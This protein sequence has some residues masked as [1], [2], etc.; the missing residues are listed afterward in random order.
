MTKFRCPVCDCLT[1]RTKHSYEICP[2]CYWEDADDYSY[3]DGWSYCNG[4]NIVEAK[5]SFVSIGVCDAEFIGCVRKPLKDE[6]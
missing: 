1:L 6:I 3:N 2:V 5:K 4:M